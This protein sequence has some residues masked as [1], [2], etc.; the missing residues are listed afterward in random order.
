MNSRL[1]ERISDLSISVKQLICIVSGTDGSTSG[2]YYVITA[3]NLLAL[4][5]N[6]VVLSTN[7]YDNTGNISV[8]NPISAGKPQQFYQMK[9]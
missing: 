6:W 1:S 2:T 9:Q 5:T 3:T 8:T 4:R 7:N